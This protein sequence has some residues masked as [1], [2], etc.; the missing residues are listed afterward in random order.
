MNYARTSWVKRVFRRRGNAV[1]DM[2]LVMPV[3]L[4]LTF[5]TVEYG[6][7]F[8]V[9]HC[10]QGAA[11]EGARVAI[12]SSAD[13]A[14]VTSAITNAMTACGLQSSGYTVTLTPSNISGLAEGTSITVSVQC[15]W[16]TV[17]MRPMKL[18]GSAKVVQGITVMRK[19][20]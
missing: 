5:G 11:R 15:T 20:S 19:E 4:S 7:Y 10:L 1:L 16:G 6:H 14:A 3:L 2:A 13:N 12:T 9:K 18:I 17:G 8:Y